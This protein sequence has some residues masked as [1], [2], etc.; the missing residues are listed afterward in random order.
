VQKILGDLLGVSF[1]K[2]TLYDKS[3]KGHH[4]QYLLPLLIFLNKKKIEVLF[5]TNKKV[6]DHHLHNKIKKLAQVKYLNISENK[7]PFIRILDD[8]KNI[9]KT[10]T[11]AYN[12][13]TDILHFLYFDFLE[14]PL[15]LFNL[16]NKS[17]FDFKVISTLHW[18]HFSGEL[19]GEKRGIIRSIYDSVQKKSIGFLFKKEKINKL[20][21]HIEEI[22]PLLQEEL[23]IN[24][25]YIKTIPYP[26]DEFKNI[27]NKDEARKELNL[28]KD[29]I[30]FLYFGGLRYDKGIDLLLQSAKNIKKDFKVI[31]AGKEDYFNKN[32]IESMI[33]SYNIKDNII[34]RIEFIPDN[35]MGLYFISSDAVVLPYR[36]IF[37]GQSGPLLQACYVK[38]PIIAFDSGVLGKIIKNNNLGI[39]AESESVNDL[40]KKLNYF[41]E[42][43]KNIREKFSLNLQEYYKKNT[44]KKMTEKVYN[45]YLKEFN[46]R[47]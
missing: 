14:I 38:K 22:R 6:E 45:I 42:N 41:I 47:R 30:L 34:K 40:S 10:Y 23:N 12:W 20:L 44:I 19:F 39:L 37:K 1:M 5:I 11:Y 35:E 43:Q 15:F 18:I 2:I 36:N 33:K 29:D 7:N 17:K 3:I 16:I 31:I 32:D 27:L 21:V 28:P 9:K 25:H 4:L 13:G 8:L 46:D 24:E 26:T